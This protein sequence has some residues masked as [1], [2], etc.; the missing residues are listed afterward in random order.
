MNLMRTSLL[1]PPILV[2]SMLFASVFADVSAQMI[3]G[4]WKGRINRQKVELKIVQKGD[5]LTGTSYYFESAANYRRYSIKGYFDAESGEAVWWDDRLIEEKSGRFNLSSPGRIAMLSRADFNCPGGGRM[6]LDGKAVRKNDLEQSGGDLHL[7]KT[8]QSQFGDEWDFIIDNYTAGTNDPYLIDSVAAIAYRPFAAPPRP[9]P[10]TQP[11]PTA[12]SAPASS[13]PAS[14]TPAPEPV[15]QTDPAPPP[16]IE[17]VKPITQAGT[18]LP[19]K[20]VGTAVTQP[21]VLAPLP[22]PP[23]TIVQKFKQREKIFVKEIPIE[24]DS[25]ELRFYDN[26]E[27]DGDSISVFLNSEI[28][29]SHIRLTAKAFSVKLAVADLAASNE[30]TMVAENLGSIPPNTSYMLALV[31]GKRYEAYLSSSEGTSAM[32]RLTKKVP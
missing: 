16:I 1:A 29:C 26:A 17:S 12:G 27:I 19:K 15:V 18:D 31:N 4:N 32:I 30:L 23:P 24:G 20:P 28:L 14:A 13:P 22:P 25:I 8:D 21:Q 9:L 6:M 5:S 3:T 7:D 10:P 2:V 11:A